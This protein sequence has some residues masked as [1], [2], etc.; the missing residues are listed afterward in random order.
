MG[1]RYK[2][3]PGETLAGYPLE[4]RKTIG[5]G[6]M[7]AVYEAMDTELGILRAVKVLDV[8]VTGIGGKEPIDELRQE[9]RVMARLNQRCK[10]YIVQ[11]LYVGKTKDSRGSL[12][13]V[14]ER[15]VGCSL[16]DLLPEGPV[17]W[18]NAKQIALHVGEALA[19]AHEDG[20]V[21]RDIKPANIYCHSP[22]EV[23]D[24]KFVLLDFGIAAIVNWST[25]RFKGTFKYAAPEQTRAPAI[26]TAQTDIY[27]L[28]IVLYEILTGRHPFE[29]HK[30]N[31]DLIKAHRNITPPPLSYFAKGAP[32]EIDELIGAM[33][34]KEPA[35]RPESMRAVVARVMAIHW[36]DQRD[37][38]PVA[39]TDTTV[40]EVGT[41]VQNVEEER[42]PRAVALPFAPTDPIDLPSDEQPP[43]VGGSTL[44]S[45]IPDE[46]MSPAP[47]PAPVVVIEQ[48]R[49]KPQEAASQ[50]PS[51]NPPKT[52]KIHKPE[53]TPYDPSQGSNEFRNTSTR[54][55]RLPDVTDPMYGAPALPPGFE[56]ARAAARAADHRQNFGGPR[57]EP[58][59]LPLHA[60]R[61]LLVLFVASVVCALCAGAVFF[62][63]RSLD[64]EAPIPS[65]TI[66]QAPIAR[67][68]TT[69]TAAPSPVVS[70]AT[71]QNAP[72]ASASAALPVSTP[73]VTAT[74]PATTAMPA[75][76]ADAVKPARRSPIPSAS[77]DP[78]VQLFKKLPGSGL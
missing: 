44:K 24:T 71:I 7:A 60:P 41:M 47:R 75:R 50:A 8:G 20:I 6:G 54:S 13:I 3:P 70:S 46:R 48:S 76:T 2:Y 38:K 31:A 52:P 49:V 57:D 10:D 68:T 56:Q 17:N 67:A 43:P 23:R 34:A 36:D 27:S 14:M 9:A 26:V 37:L 73:A 61:W 35:H 65:P 28:G 39:E 64:A 18:D 33:I 66:A 69:Q 53:P 40:Q 5:S 15:L 19:A 4:I 11:V 30:S 78:D 77:A 74:L 22:P 1:N 58:V 62:H 12:F 29:D 55:A 25:N 45:Q 32:P 16:K 21:H 42:Q 63:M 51:A 59:E 72:V